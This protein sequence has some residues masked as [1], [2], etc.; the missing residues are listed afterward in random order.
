VRHWQA[1]GSPAQ[2]LARTT[3]LVH[4]GAGW[5]PVAPQALVGVA[6]GEALLAWCTGIAACQCA[7]PGC[8]GRRPCME[9]RCTAARPLQRGGAS[10]AQLCALAG[11]PART[12]PRLDVVD[13]AAL[14]SR[15]VQRRKH[16]L[17]VHPSGIP[18]ALIRG[19]AAPRKPR[20]RQSKVRGRAP[21]P[22]RPPRAWATCI[23]RVR[24]SRRP[25]S[26]PQTRSRRTTCRRH[27]RLAAGRTSALAQRVSRLPAAVRRRRRSPEATP[28]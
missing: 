3:H 15:A 13:P 5:L 9:L 14:V 12:Q 25:A 4:A 23:S 22:R 7:H 6:V 17:P 18:V 11:A 27:S 2:L 10:A 16:A 1:A 20:Q 26:R 8:G 24:A 28:R 19:P 21:P